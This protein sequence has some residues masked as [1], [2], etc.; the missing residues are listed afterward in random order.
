MDYFKDSVICENDREDE[1]LLDHFLK[2]L[3]LVWSPPCP[4]KTSTFWKKQM[5]SAAAVITEAPNS[6]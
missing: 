1:N 4:V 6:L 2:C 3:A 5:D